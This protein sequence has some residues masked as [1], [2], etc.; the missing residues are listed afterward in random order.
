VTD[1]SAARSKGAAMTSR[2]RSPIAILLAAGLILA[3]PA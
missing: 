2:K 1:V 3:A